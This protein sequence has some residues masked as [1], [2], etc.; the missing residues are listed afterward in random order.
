MNR[1][2]LGIHLIN[3]LSYPQ[4]FTL[5]GFLFAIPLTWV[6]YL[7]ICEINSLVYFAQ[8]I[9]YGN[10]YLRPLRQL[11]EYIPKL[12]LL[13]YQNL[14]SNLSNSESRANLE[15]KIDANFQSLANT[16]PQLGNLLVSS[17]NLNK[18]NENLQNLKLR[19]SLWSLETYDF[20]YQRLAADINRLSARVGD[21]S[22]LTFAPDLA[23]YYLI[24]PTW[25]NLPEMQK[26]L[27]E[28]RLISQKISLRS[29]PT[30]EEKAQLI[31]LS[32]KLREI[33]DDLAIN[34]EV[35]FSN[36]P[37][38]NLRL[39]LTL[40]LNKINSLVKQLTKQLAQRIY[41]SLLIKHD[42]YINGDNLAFD[43]SWGV[44]NKIVN[45]LKF[46]LEH[47]II[48]FVI[49]P[50]LLVNLV[51][52]IGKY[53]DIFISF[54]IAAMQ[55]VFVLDEASKKMAS[56]N[57]ANK[58]I[59]DNR[60]APEQ[61]VGAFN[62]IADALIGKNQ[63]ITVFKYGLKA[64]NRRMI[65]ELDL[66]RKIQQMHLPKNREIKEILA[67]DIAGFM[68]AAEEVGGDYYEVL[69]HKGRVKFG[70]DDVT[71]HGWD[72]GV[73]MIVVQ[74]AFPTW[75]ADNEPEQ[76]K[77]LSAINCVIYDNVE[78]VKF[79]KNA[80]LALLDY[81][82]GMVKLSGQRE[83]MIVVRCNGCVE[84]F[85]TI[86]LGFQI[87]LDAEI[88]EFFVETSV[89]LYSGDVVVLYTDGIT[90]A[91]NMDKLLYGL[92]RL[93]EVIEINW[94]RSAAEIRDAVIKDLR[95]HIG[96]Q[97]VF[98]DITLLVLKQK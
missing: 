92:D 16:D 9:F 37:Q 13:N 47:R 78:R 62:K 89:Q 22:H 29:D 94:Q 83:E 98:D 42:A 20:V 41:Q 72:S 45:K 75:L 85:D 54:Y 58:V 66:T 2:S 31:T 34:M 44:G 43:S 8:N 80:S 25:L 49:L 93:I 87:G 68:E 50:H 4:K 36:N 39:K 97:K 90:E 55:T 10:Q 79:D 82:Q 19:R 74:T 7:L 70:R 61:V 15:A 6:M 26:I 95:S 52:K 76:V 73:L 88:S 65:S 3:L 38:G 91:E 67:L 46:S 53:I 60:D 40:N 23:I 56:D 86:D 48:F 27:S 30:P 64:E 81:Q 33:N 57:L 1:K 32:S 71:G 5:I 11:R 96:E 28:I 12:Q 69:Q 59:L 63:E 84:R 35:A 24:N 14:N 21:T 51:A 18:F 17:E 77:I